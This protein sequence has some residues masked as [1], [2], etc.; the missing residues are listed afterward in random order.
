M[1]SESTLDIQQYAPS[2]MGILLIH[3][4]NK[5]SMAASVHCLPNN[6]SHLCSSSVLAIQENESEE[7]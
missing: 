6:Y 1:H 5:T 7:F 2:S 4:L 3:L